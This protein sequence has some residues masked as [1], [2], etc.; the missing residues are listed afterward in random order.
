VLAAGSIAG[1]VV[2]SAVRLVLVGSVGRLV[3]HDFATA[4]GGAGALAFGVRATLVV[5]AAFD[6]GF[7][8][9]R[10]TGA[11]SSCGSAVSSMGALG[12]PARCDELGT[13][14]STTMPATH[15]AA[16]AIHH[17]SLRRKDK[18]PVACSTGTA[19]VAFLDR[20]VCRTAVFFARTVRVGLF[21]FFVRT[22]TLLSEILCRA[23]SA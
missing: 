22:E 17:G 3:T 23:L 11:A 9:S 15:T 12:R 4:E 10:E 5:R 8:V 16:N 20:L 2:G 21:V 1:A 18:D 13:P 14:I 7:N 6:T 19:S